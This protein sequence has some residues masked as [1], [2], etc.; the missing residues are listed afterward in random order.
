MTT[1]HDSKCTQTPELSIVIPVYNEQRILEDAVR[2]L[3]DAIARAPSLANR[4]VELLLC[5]NGCVDDTVSVAKTLQHAFPAIR[6]LVDDEPNYGRA[7]KA[8]IL[9]ARAPIVICD[10]IDLCDTD[11]YVR[12]LALIEQTGVDLVVGSKRLEPGFDQRPVV[13]KVATRVING[14]LRLSTGFKGTDTHGLKAF[15][16]LALTPIVRACVVDKDMFASELVIRAHRSDCVAVEIPVRIHEKRPPS[17][18]LTK[19][20]PTVLRQLITLTWVIRSS[21]KPNKGC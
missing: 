12:A 17:I 2:G 9:D 15:R 1:H 7:L 4:S 10:E 18:R 11:F 21:P 13:R 6:L 16:R 14:L 5:A 3:F 20:V 8:G 19:R